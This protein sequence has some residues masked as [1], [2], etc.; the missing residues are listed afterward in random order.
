MEII[1]NGFTLRKWQRDD[2]AELQ[3]LA[4]NPK[5]AA[6][7]YNRFPSPYTMAD[8]ESFIN[9]KINDNPATSFVIEVDGRFAGTIGIDFR[10]DVFERSPVIGYWLGEEFWGRGIMTEAAKLMTAYAFNQFDIICLQAGVFGCNPASMRVLE[11]AGYLKQGIL[12]G[13]VYK[14][15]RVLDE[16]IYIRNRN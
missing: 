16:H 14:N 3:R 11:N 4:G 6:N 9:L 8:A 13:V 5:I 15:G 2:A 1:G 10:S 7:L 12:K